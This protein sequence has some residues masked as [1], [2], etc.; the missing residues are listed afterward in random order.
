MHNLWAPW[1]IEYILSKKQPG[2]IFC[3]KVQEDRDRENYILHRGRTAFIMLNTYPYNNGHLMVIPYAHV[4]SIEELSTEAVTE[5]MQLVQRSVRALRKSCLPE[6]FNIG[7][8]I[9]R[10]AGAGVA[11][12]VHMHV[13]PR[14]HGDTN[15]MG[16]LA[17]THT[18][19]ELLETTYDRLIAAGLATPPLTGQGPEQK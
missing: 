3:D 16:V 10:S 1:R 19:P 17:N 12:H 7:M 14:W 5:M 2:C 8:N 18:I 15:Y 4:G 11:D 9:G 13:V 6:G